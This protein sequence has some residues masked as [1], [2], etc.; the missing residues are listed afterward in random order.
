MACPDASRDTN[1]QHRAAAGHRQRLT[2]R[3]QDA[4]ADYDVHPWSIK[5]DD[6]K[7]DATSSNN[8]LHLKV[9]QWK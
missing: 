4:I 3:K 6:P 2:D 1:E 8:P 7:R 5:A 9:R